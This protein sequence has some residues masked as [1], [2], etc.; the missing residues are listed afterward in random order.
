VPDPTTSTDVPTPK[1]IRELVTDNLSSSGPKVKDTVVTALTQ[2]EINKRVETVRNALPLVDTAR[3]VL[4][5]FKADVIT[6][7]ED[8]SVKDEGWSKQN[9]EAKKQ[10]QEKLAKLEAA[11]AKALD[12]SQFEDL[13]KLVGQASSQGQKSTKE[14]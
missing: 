6:Y 1:S 4:K 2:E 14:E 9:L 8:G 10:A 7:N 5:K 12:E 11:L 13:N 3:G